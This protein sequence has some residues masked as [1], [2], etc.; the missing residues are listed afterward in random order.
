MSNVDAR[1][2]A[3]LEEVI[4]TFLRLESANIGSGIS[5][6]NLCGRLSIAFNTQLEA[7]GFQG[8]F[9]DPEYN[10]KQNGEIKTILDEEYQVVTINCDL[11]VHTRGASVRHD[12]L[13]A[14]EMKKSNRPVNDKNNDR[15]RQSANQEQL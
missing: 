6:R 12:N 14:I 1:I 9:V 7:H 5:E 11:I 8:Y 13:I 10:R 4:D 2:D 15:R 3:M